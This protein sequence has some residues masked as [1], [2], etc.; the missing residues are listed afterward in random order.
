[1]IVS[2]ELVERMMCFGFVEDGEWNDDVVSLL[3][4]L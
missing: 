4:D 1:M 3:K 2:V